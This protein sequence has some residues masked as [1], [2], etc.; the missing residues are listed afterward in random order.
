MRVPVNKIVVSGSLKKTIRKMFFQKIEMKEIENKTGL[1][2]RVI[3]RVVRENNW[4]DVRERYYRMLCHVS[5]INSTPLETI[6]KKTGVNYYGLCRIRKKYDIP[7]AKRTAWNDRRS[8]ALENKIISLYKDGRTGKEIADKFGYKRKETV[9]QVLDKHNIERREPKIQT[10]YDESFFERIDTHE[11]AYVLGLIMTDGW[12]LKNYAGFGIQ[13]TEEDG[14]I[15]EKIS[16]LIG[17]TNSITHINYN[18][19]RKRL[20]GAKDM[21][22]LTVHNRKIAED[23][24]KLGVIKNK[25]TVMRYNDCVPYEFLSSFF[26]GLIDGDG[27]IGVGKNGTCRCSLY[28]SSLMF[29]KDIKNIEMP[30]RFSVIQDG[31][32]LNVLGGKDG[33]ISFLRWVYI[34]QS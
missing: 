25:T 31:K 30:F 13:L 1:T 8:D 23:L 3:R 4:I 7:K 19:M 2:E 14:Y 34:Q 26:R 17:S 20:N 10:Y 32:N 33:V 28:S 22:R 21:K 29:I 12:I 18:K 16:D 24:K 15:L 27:H 6:A 5:L 9:Y 11:K